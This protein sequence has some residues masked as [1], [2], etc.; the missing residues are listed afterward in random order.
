MRSIQG[1]TI[2]SNAVKVE[3]KRPAQSAI[4]VSSQKRARLEDDKENAIRQHVVGRKKENQVDKD[5]K[6]LMDDLMAGL[7]ASMFS[8]PVK[9]QA[10]IQS[11]R[12]PVRITG[13]VE[14]QVSP[15]KT[16]KV[17]KPSPLRPSIAK[18]PKMP[19]PKG[20]APQ[21][22]KRIPKAFVPIK[23][24]V[25]SATPPNAV[26]LESKADIKPVEEIKLDVRPVLEDDDEFTFDLDLDGL[27]DMDDDLLLKP[28][29]AAKVCFFIGQS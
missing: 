13:R 18:R 10:Q 25:E 22:M 29:V 9:S 12:S 20:T 26:V 11:Q 14:R 15:V 5:E 2:T 6:A 8:S 17:E 27:A 28:H 24:E 4:K 7:D 19:V 1:P 23:I 3:K 21:V 16:V